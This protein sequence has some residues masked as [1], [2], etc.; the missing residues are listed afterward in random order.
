MP[1]DGRIAAVNVEPSEFVNVGEVLV[2]ADSIDVAEVEAQLAI[3]RMAPLVRADIDLSSLSAGELALVPERLGLK[4]T[5]HLR[6]DQVTASW[7][8]RFERLSD[9]IDPQTRT[10]GVIVTVEEPY[11]KAIPGERPPL[12]KDMFVEVELEG[13]P[14]EAALV[15][16]RVAVHRRPDGSAALYLVGEADRLEIRPV[17]LGPAQG[18]VVV[19]TGGIAPGARVVVSD[20]VPAIEGMKLE[21]TGDVTLGQRIAAEATHGDPAN[22]LVQ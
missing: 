6:A 15:V 13:R 5:V 2:V 19:V 14:R 3:S 10:I 9:R 12:A 16:P 7:D 1:F 18:D 21:A 17:T 22:A 20:L 8:A 4:A 11:R